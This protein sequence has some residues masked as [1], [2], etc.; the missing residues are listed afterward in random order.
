M[1][2]S[3]YTYLIYRIEIGDGPDQLVYTKHRKYEAHNWMTHKK[4]DPNDYY[5]VRAKEEMIV[6]IP[7]DFRSS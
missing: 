7:W 4:L 2:Y 1:S 3:E 6:R 5:L